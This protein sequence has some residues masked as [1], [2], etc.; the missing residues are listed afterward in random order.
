MVSLKMKINNNSPERMIQLLGKDSPSSMEDRIQIIRNIKNSVIG[1]SYKKLIYL[2]MGIIHVLTPY[3][4]DTSIIELSIQ[5]AIVIAS[6]AHKKVENQEEVQQVTQSLLS[7]L[8]HPNQRLVEASARALKSILSLSLISQ[9]LDSKNSKQIISTIIKLMDP[10]IPLNESAIANN[11]QYPSPSSI[12]PARIRIAEVAII[13]FGHLQFLPEDINTCESYGVFNLCV[14]LL[15]HTW[16]IYPRL[17]K[18]VITSLSL[19]SKDN[20]ILD[21]LL[22]LK[23]TYTGRPITTLV[24]DFIH[25]QDPVTRLYSSSLLINLFKLSKSLNGTSEMEWI[26]PSVLPT[27]IKLIEYGIDYRH[28]GKINKETKKLQDK[29]NDLKD[30][31]NNE[32]SK[33]SGSSIYD[34]I[35]EENIDFILLNSPKVFIDLI[36]NNDILKQA[37]FDGNSILKLAK[38][39][40]EGSKNVHININQGTSNFF[41]PATPSIP[42]TDKSLNGNLNDINNYCLDF[43]NSIGIQST[44]IIDSDIDNKPLSNE[45]LEITLSAITEF[46]STRDDCKKAVIDS[47]VLPYIVELLKH[48][49]PK[50][51]AAACNTAKVL[52]RSVKNL[53]TSLVDAG[54]SDP[55]LQLLDDESIEV[56]NCACATICNIVLDFSPMKLTFVEKGGVKRLIDLIDCNNMELRINALWALKNLLYQSDSKIKNQVMDY[57]GWTKLRELTDDSN[58]EIREQAMNLIRNIACG[59]ASDIKLVVD[60]FGSDELMNCVEK[61]LIEPNDNVV[62]QTLYVMA[63]ISTGGSLVK[64]LIMDNDKILPHLN[65]IILYLEPRMKVAAIRVIDNLIS[66]GGNSSERIEKLITMGFS[67]KLDVLSSDTNVD[68]KDRALAILP[69]FKKGKI[70][71]DE[72]MSEDNDYYEEDL[73][74]NNE[75]E[76]EDFDEGSE[77]DAFI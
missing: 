1:S 73:N 6:V 62:Y 12:P 56:K 15:E 41:T 48:D 67:D 23:C 53:R 30:K 38:I 66:T 43:G 13:I 26:I 59:R 35:S 75:D 49:S 45:I 18:A 20:T 19:I 63:N 11:A 40:K 72:S 47:N 33:F 44:S 50:V 39:L 5:S 76:D 29:S 3:L 22:N 42:S 61:R 65:D 8:S 60:K 27:V 34:G 10:L 57:L 25:N 68:V 77:S 37:A 16:D 31:S 54:I 70:E 46:S 55:L 74:V 2:K 28:S 32:I 36:S 52:S 69:Y 64:S 17:Q 4:L 7:L 21:I 51:R 71:E 58:A 9:S 24:L 14:N